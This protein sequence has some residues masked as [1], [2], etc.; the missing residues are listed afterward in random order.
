MAGHTATRATAVNNSGMATFA[1]CV[2]WG[3]YLGPDAVAGQCPSLLLEPSTIWASRCFWT[4][5]VW[6]EVGD[7]VI[8]QEV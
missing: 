7:T 1:S 2:P 5:L 8:L 3:E 6:T 4:A